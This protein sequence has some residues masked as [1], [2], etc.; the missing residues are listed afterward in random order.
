MHCV[1][2]RLPLA[3]AALD[4][5]EVVDTS[6]PHNAAIHIY[7]HHVCDALKSVREKGWGEASPW[8]AGRGEGEKGE[9]A[10]TL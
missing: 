8:A 10:L 2:T 7:A 5:R 4:I 6:H 3:P 1:S 9:G